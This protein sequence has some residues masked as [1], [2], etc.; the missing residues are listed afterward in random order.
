VLGLVATGCAIDFEEPSNVLDLRTLAIRAEPPELL[1]VGPLPAVELRALVVDPRDPLREVTARWRAC[2]STTEHRCDES[3]VVLDLGATTSALPE[4]GATLELEP[5]LLDGA[6]RQDLLQ[7][8]GGL[9]VVVEVSIEEGGPDHEVAFKEVVVQAVLPEGTAPNSNPG[10]PGLLRDDAAWPED[11]VPVIAPGVEVAIE[12]TS[13]AGDAEPYA[14]FRF[15]LGT[16]E[17]VEHIG[18]RFFATAGQWN[19]EQTGG[20]PN[21]IS[22]ET[23]VASR[24]TAPEE[25]PT[26]GGLVTIWV[27]ARDGR[28]GISWTERQ[29]EVR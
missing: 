4:L 24:W 11:E 16:Q 3:A 9:P 17:L 23:T 26:G 21:A 12:P 5:A 29:V 2:G 20:P 7:G 8:F 19:R 28:G 18:Y 22:T 1:A 14:V 25:P 13:A 27:V 10:A 15:D 6:R